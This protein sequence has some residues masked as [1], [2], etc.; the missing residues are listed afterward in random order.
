MPYLPAMSADYRF[1]SSFKMKCHVPCYLIGRICHCSNWKAQLSS[2]GFIWHLLN[3]L[4]L[5]VYCGDKLKFPFVV[6]LSMDFTY[7]KLASY[8]LFHYILL[9]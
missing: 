5:Y 8:A 4:L 7:L 6:S 2:C 1:L 3:D 9:K